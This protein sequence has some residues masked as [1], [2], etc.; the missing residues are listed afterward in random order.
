LQPEDGDKP[1][2]REVGKETFEPQ[3]IVQPESARLWN[4]SSATSDS[5]SGWKDEDSSSG[6]DDMCKL[7][8]KQ[9][10]FTKISFI[11]TE[12]I[13]AIVPIEM[14]NHEQAIPIGERPDADL[15]GRITLA[16]NSGEVMG[17]SINQFG[18]ASAVDITAA[19]ERLRAQY[20]AEFEEF[21]TAAT[22]AA[23]ENRWAEFP[24][25]FPAP[26]AK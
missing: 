23:I 26:S 1:F 12:P 13:I 3:Y 2:V 10:F 20:D 16:D 15:E 18:F 22:R 17:L 9:E 21:L 4:T 11:N 25:Y 7:P 6:S 5:W 19:Y 14:P 24:M 8:L